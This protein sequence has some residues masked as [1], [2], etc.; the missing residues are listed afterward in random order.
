MKDERGERTGGF[1]RGNFLKAGAVAA[2]AAGAGGAGRALAGVPGTAVDA[3]PGVGKL[4]G[5][6]AFLHR[7]SWTPLVG[8]RF[9]LS[10]P[11]QKA[12]RMQLIAATPHRSPGEAFSL[13]F[14]GHR[15]AAAESGVYRIQHSSLGSVELF[16]SP[17]GRGVKGLDLEAVVNRVAT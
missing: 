17:I 5:G 9:K 8:D 10:L 15:D 3:G 7:P 2:L 11:G 4:R 6:A 1:S 14:R 16:L 13:V 12:L